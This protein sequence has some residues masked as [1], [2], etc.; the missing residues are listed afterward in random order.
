MSLGHILY[1]FIYIKNPDLQL[2]W[3]SKNHGCIGSA[4][5]FP[6]DSAPSSLPSLHYFS[7]AACFTHLP[8]VLGPSKQIQIGTSNL[9]NFQGHTHGWR[10]LCKRYNQQSCLGFLIW[11]MQLDFGDPFKNTGIRLYLYQIYKFLVKQYK[12]V[13]ISQSNLYSENIWKSWPEVSIVRW[14]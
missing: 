2:S 8:Y 9:V 1:R 5:L 13:P 11:G 6:Q 3:K 10:E 12:D 7:Q 4:F 14:K